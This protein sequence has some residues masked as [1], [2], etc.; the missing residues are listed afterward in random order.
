MSSA[1]DDIISVLEF[2]LSQ[3]TPTG[4]VAEAMERLRNR[5][6]SGIHVG[7]KQPPTGE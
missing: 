3:K 5:A 6:K 4:Q 1:V 7:A 2:L